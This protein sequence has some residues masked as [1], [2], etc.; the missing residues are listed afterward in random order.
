[1]NGIFGGIVSRKI[2][3]ISAEPQ[4]LLGSEPNGVGSGVID[5]IF[6]QPPGLMPASPTE[7]CVT[8]MKLEA[9]GGPHS[10]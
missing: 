1:M 6:H 5:Y 10:Q 2:R 7:D 8:R 3:L 4:P 9:R